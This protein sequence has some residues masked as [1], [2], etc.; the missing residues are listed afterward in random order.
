MEHEP[1][2][3]ELIRTSL[4][5]SRA[6]RTWLEARMRRLGV[7][8]LGTMIRMVIRETMNAEQIAAEKS[9]CA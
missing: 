5:I 2:A 1:G 4:Q 3:D 8:S 7:R 9:D 6:Q